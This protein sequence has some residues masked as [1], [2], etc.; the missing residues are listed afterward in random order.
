MG[1]SVFGSDGDVG[2]GSGKGPVVIDP[3]TGT[4]FPPFAPAA[5]RPRLLLGWQYKASVASLLSADAASV[6]Q[7]PAD[8]PVSGFAA[9]GAAQLSLTNASITA[10]ETSAFAAAERAVANA[11]TRNALLAGCVPANATDENCLRRALEPFLYRAF[12]R[13]V[14]DAE[15]ATWVNVGKTAGAAYNNFNKGL[16]FAIAGVLQSPQFLYQVE[17]GETDPEHPER[18]RL[19][20]FELATRMSFFLAGAPPS[21]ALLD[22]AAG[23][24]L[25]TEAGVREEATALMQGAAAREALG[26]F[27]EEFWGLHELSSLSKNAEAFPQ[28]TPALRTAMGEEAKLLIENIVFE[29]N[30]DFR[31]AFDANYTYVNAALGQLYGVSGAPATGFGRVVLPPESRRGGLFGQAAFLAL[32]SHPL[33]TSP[34]FRGKFIRE[35]ILCQPVAA[36][37]NDVVTDL[38]NTA[39]TAKTMREKLAEHQINPS[40]SGCHVLMDNLGFALE[41]FDALGQFRTAE[42]GVTIDAKS[43][44][45]DLGSFTGA[46]ELGTALRNNDTT[47]R[48]F[49]RNLFRQATGHVEGQGEGISLHAVD[50]AF[51]GSGFRV[52]DLM[53]EIVASEAFR[54]G[55][56]ETL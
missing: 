34:T 38:S 6:V 3:K 19:T 49:A 22:A 40:C 8:T 1:S 21:E 41:N 10:Y 39:S 28:Y 55:A 2:A 9:V 18:L 13:E 11:S 52:K 24:K 33:T 27:F 35:K 17:V 53:V 5:L 37:P 46:R 51:T 25:S 47:M 20:G 26:H 31:D 16:E 45:P 4:P 44:S 36:A 32:H 29:A 7:P 50:E 48:C 23:G 15:L 14:N 56:K 30:G 43:S 54:A 42:N 12:R